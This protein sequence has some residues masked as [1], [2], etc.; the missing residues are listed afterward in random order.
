M[1]KTNLTT[2]IFLFVIFSGSIANAA[3]KT[4]ILNSKKDGLKITSKNSTGLTLESSISS[5]KTYQTSTSKGVFTLLSLNGYSKNQNIGKAQLP[6]LNKLV[7]IP[8]DATVKINIIS[9]DE[10]I[11][12]LNDLGF[13][14]KIL[15]TQPSYSK[16]TNPSDIV[17][18]YNQNYYNTNAFDNNEI[19]KF[20]L[21][22]TMRGI[23]FGS[24]SICPFSYNPV[25]N[26]LKVYNN[27]KI[28]LIFENANIQL[29]QEIKNKYNSPFYNSLLS[30]DLINY[31]AS[32]AKDLITQY[33]IKYVIVSD[34]MFQTNLQPFIQWKTRKG[35]NVIEAYTNNPAVGTTNTSIKTYLEGLYTTATVTNPA[36]TFVLFVGDVAQIPTFDGQAESHKTDLY[37]CTFDGTTD[38]LPDMYYGRFSAT[39]TAQL[40]PQIE[41]TMEYEQYT[42]PDPAYLDSVVMVAGVDNGSA[43]DG[44]FSEI[45]ANGQINYGTSNYFNAHGITST[46]YLWPETNNSA[47]DIAMRAKIGK[48]VSYANYTAH[49][50]S[51][52]WGDPNFVT[53]HIPSMVN[54]HKYGLI[55]GNCCQSNTFNDPECFGEALLRA[56]KKGAVGYIGASNSS[57]WDED[58]YWGVGNTATIIANPTYDGTGLGAYDRMFH[59]HAE[60]ESEWFITNAQ[61]VVGGN[62]AVEASTSGSKKYYWEIY[63]L[64]GDPSVMNYF[65]VPE[66]LT[67]SYNNPIIIGETNLTVNT[68][69]YAYVAISQ[70][71]ILLN[72]QYTGT[73]T[74]VTLT[75]PA[76]SNIG[77]ADIV[78]TKQNK[79]P[80][81]GTV[82]IIN[83]TLVNNAQMFAITHPVTAYNTANS[84]LTPTFT[85]KSMGTANMTTLQVA[86]KLDNETPVYKSWNGNL[87]LYET[88]IITFPS[89]TLTEGSHTF[90][91]Y[92]YLPNNSQDEYL[93]NDTLK[94]MILVSSGDVQITIIDTPLNSYCS[95]EN[96]QPSIT[97]KNLDSYNLTSL[98]ASYN[99]NGATNI[100]QNWN[101]NLA[102]NETATISFPNINLTAG[103]HTFNFAVSNPNGGTDSNT[104]NNTMSKN[105]STTNGPTVK[106][107]LHTDNYGSET[108]W[109]LK[110]AA[111]ISLNTSPTY[112]NI[113]NGALYTYEFCLPEGCYTFTIN[114]SNA[115]GICCGQWGDG[116]YVIT[117]IDSTETYAQ[118]G[119]F[120]LTEIKTFCV[121]TPNNITSIEKE[122]IKI[123]P[124]PTNGNINISSEEI[125]NKIEI[126]NIIGECVVSK[127]LNNINTTI[128][129]SNLQ[130]GIY[131]IKIY[132]LKNIKVEQIIL[133]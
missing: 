129:L 130:K 68:E 89:I 4:I 112:V 82:D 3:N 116:S 55:V 45:H 114:D 111:G 20:K 54:E 44:G 29:T 8:Q 5:I 119:Q 60:A 66:T 99:I 70:N 83:N 53:S 100:L 118:G 75:F 79:A 109:V 56:A 132:S 106:L 65:G 30:K 25:Q 33:P 36:P 88:D 84:T 77:T 107:N 40:L 67:V 2:L 72:A 81:I 73:N 87:A 17:F 18:Q 31:Q 97:I 58:Y 32:Q 121:G 21:S 101:G 92:T 34:P 113:T 98:T 27:I 57:Y 90:T 51:E 37:Y 125:I 28:E 85:I 74:S 96:I 78:I 39:N 38:N 86:Y 71:N 48:G 12:N 14:N 133:N 80:Y 49:C 123:Y 47:T 69:P 128:N 50:G 120:G 127:N 6:I 103:S 126:Y 7:E 104:A 41:K 35:F 1:I 117:N 22:G 59:D 63:H 93:Q 26:T 62:L 15:P 10:E 124:N 19:A 42:M 122:Q 16:N 131:F 61:M 91:A 43:P 13:T 46:T 64:M 95:L 108:S 105:I 102:Q 24:L 23:R 110:N 9:Y 115:D 52:G 76:F 11:I 94:R